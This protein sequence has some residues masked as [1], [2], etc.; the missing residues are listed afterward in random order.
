MK[1]A[2]KSVHFSAKDDFFETSRQSWTPQLEQKQ[3][4][5]RNP[6]ERPVMCVAPPSTLSRPN[7]EGTY[8]ILDNR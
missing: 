1:G 8:L 7:Y 2:S 5:Y 4:V 3:P 6:A